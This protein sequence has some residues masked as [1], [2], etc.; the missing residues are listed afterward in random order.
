MSFRR[1]LDL[2]SS[3]SRIVREA[4]VLRPFPLPT[5]PTLHAPV[6]R[7]EDF[8]KE[9]LSLIR[10]LY[11]L[12]L[13]E[14]SEPFLPKRTWLKRQRFQECRRL[15]RTRTR[16]SVCLCCA[17]FPLPSRFLLLPPRQF[18][19]SPVL[20]FSSEASKEARKAAAFPF[21]PF[22]SSTACGHTDAYNDGHT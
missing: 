3:L 15:R 7:R 22:C 5:V 18:Q 2:F 21:A 10:S 14:K 12:C 20:S 1:T 9:P 16:L 17:I 4:R 13:F 6:K 11:T 19:L 8:D